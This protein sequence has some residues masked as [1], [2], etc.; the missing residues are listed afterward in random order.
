MLMHSALIDKGNS[1][2]ALVD[3]N[4]KI[5]G[6]NFAGNPQTNTFPFQSVQGYAIPINNVHIFL[7]EKGLG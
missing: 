6:I 4:L 5:I 2:G 7:A 3:I 1:G